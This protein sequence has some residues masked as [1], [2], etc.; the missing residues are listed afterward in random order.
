MAKEGHKRR[1]EDNKKRLGTY[2]VASVLSLVRPARAA[3]GSRE[4]LQGL[5]VA[6]VVANNAQ[7]CTK[8]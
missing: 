4:T 5:E 6:F 3:H 1:V 7:L 2:A 8:R